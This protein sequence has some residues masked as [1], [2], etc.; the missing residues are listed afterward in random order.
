MKSCH[1]FKIL[2][3]PTRW[4]PLSEVFLL[5]GLLKHFSPQRPTVSGL[6]LAE[7]FLTISLDSYMFSSYAKLLGFPPLIFPRPPVQLLRKKAEEESF[8][9]FKY[10]SGNSKHIDF[11]YEKTFFD[12]SEMVSHCGFNLPLSDGW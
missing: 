9:L 12:L 2:Q 4:R 10:Q 11:T 7:A 8:S 6:H 3:F 1:S 5:P